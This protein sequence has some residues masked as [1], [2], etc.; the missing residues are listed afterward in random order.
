M[1]YLAIIIFQLL[2]SLINSNALPGN[3]HLPVIGQ[4]DFGKR[5]ENL[6]HGQPMGDRIILRAV[7]GVA[8]DITDVLAR[9]LAEN[10]D[11]AWEKF[12]EFFFMKILRPKSRLGVGYVASK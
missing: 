6:E 4:L 2:A 7:A 9:V 11:L 1:L 10:V 5:G 8:M 3:H 12:R